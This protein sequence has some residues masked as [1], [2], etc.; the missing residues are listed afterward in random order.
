MKRRREESSEQDQPDRKRKKVE[1]TDEVLEVKGYKNIFEAAKDGNLAAIE[2]FIGNG[3]DINAFDNIGNTPLVVAAFYGHMET[4]Q[5]LFMQEGVMQEDKNIVTRFVVEQGHMETVKWL[6]T[7]VLGSASYKFHAVKFAVDLGRTDIIKCISTQGMGSYYRDEALRYAAD[8]GNIEIVQWL[9]EYGADI[10][11]GDLKSRHSNPMGLSTNGTALTIALE[12][13]HI[14]IV[15]FLVGK[16]VAINYSTRKYQDSMLAIIESAK[17][18]DG[19]VS[20]IPPQIQE[21]VGI[22]DTLVITRY[23]F[24]ISKNGYQRTLK[25]N[26]DII[27]NTNGLSVGLK[28]EVIKVLVQSQQEIDMKC[29]SI[30]SS[31][32]LT[33]SPVSLI[34]LINKK[35]E[36][37][38]YVSEEE[39]PI[40]SLIEF[41]KEMLPDFDSESIIDFLNSGKVKN[42][43]GNILEGEDRNKA[44]DSMK[45]KISAANLIIIQNSARLFDYLQKSIIEDY[46]GVDYNE[47]K[48]DILKES[49]D[50][51]HSLAESIK[52]LINKCILPLEFKDK[53]SLVIMHQKELIL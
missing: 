40:K 31:L 53:L 12:Q 15:K 21:D 45:A 46:V 25:E 20:R 35:A 44:L 18:A 2:F 7:Q 23:K 13:G 9:V 28:Q 16:G 3:V 39:G 29:G 37:N 14:A 4:V 51:K 43:E 34:I 33:I 17:V 5:W 47:H 48:E 8:S 19:I 42:S 22:D 26:I 1:A 38:F 36:G 30:F 52:D 50:R 32:K 41:Y 10:N 49:I 24:L 11:Y 27:N 6:F